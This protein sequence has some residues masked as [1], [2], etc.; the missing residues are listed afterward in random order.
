MFSIVKDNNRSF[1]PFDLSEN[2]LSLPILYICNYAKESYIYSI[3]VVGRICC[4]N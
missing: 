1:F 2:L 4:Y 3:V